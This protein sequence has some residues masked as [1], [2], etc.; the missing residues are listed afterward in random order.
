MGTLGKD[1]AIAYWQENI[2]LMLSL[3]VVWFIASFG[4]GILFADELD[5][6]R[7]FG[8]K[9]GFWMAQQGSI[10]VFVALIFI[11]VH[12]MNKL[13]HKYGVDEDE[14]DYVED[15]DYYRHDESFIDSI[16]EHDEMPN[17]KKGD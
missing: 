17:D 11:Y 6:F 13:D 5:Q 10:Y 9:L 4:M 12:R 7:F 3:L 2:R 1:N 16:S 15:E 8:F 14:D